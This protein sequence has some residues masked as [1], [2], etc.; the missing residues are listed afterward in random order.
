MPAL[1]T[2]FLTFTAKMDKFASVLGKA[3]RRFSQSVKKMGQGAKRVG[4]AFSLMGAGIVGSLGLMTKKY[5]DNA[6]EIGDLSKKL[7]VSTEFLSEYKHVAELTGVSFGNLTTAIQRQTR[8]LSEAGKQMD[9]AKK[10]T[11]ALSA[12]QEHTPPV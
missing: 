12:K 7:G 1:G 9:V 2:Y 5:A 3:E 10:Q 6:N 11:A 4:K 8:R